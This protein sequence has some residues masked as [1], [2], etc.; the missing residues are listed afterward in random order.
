MEILRLANGPLVA[1]DIAAK[2]GLTGKRETQRRRVRELIR[3]L[4][5]NGAQIVASLTEGYRL[6][7]DDEANKRYFD[8]RQIGAKRVLGETHKKKKMLFNDR[9]QGLLFCPGGVTG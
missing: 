1:V 8:T 5:D 4:R 6:T 7:D 2:L 3:K 9:G